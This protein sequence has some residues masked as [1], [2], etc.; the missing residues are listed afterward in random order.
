MKINTLINNFKCEELE[1]VLNMPKTELDKLKAQEH[2]FKLISGDIMEHY[3]YVGYLT[4]MEQRM[5]LLV[6]MKEI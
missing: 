5:I 3:P 2:P 1:Q 6:L 4:L